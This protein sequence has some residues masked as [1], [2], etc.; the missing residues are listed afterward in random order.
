MTGCVESNIVDG[1][2]LSGRYI[3]WYGGTKCLITYKSL[4]DISS[5]VVYTTGNWGWSFDKATIYYSDDDSLTLDSDLSNFNSI[6][7]N[8]ESWQEL[9]EII[10]AK[11]VMLVKHENGAV[12]EFECLGKWDYEY[13]NGLVDYWP[14][15]N[16]LENA[17][18][19]GSG[20]LQIEKGSEPTYT[21]DGVYL[22]N[23][24]LSTQNYYVMPSKYSIVF[25]IKPTQINRWSWVAGK[26]LYIAGHS[27]YSSGLW[28]RDT[29]TEPIVSCGDKYDS[30]Y[31][32]PGVGIYN[33]NEQSTIVITHDGGTMSLYVDGNLIGT[34]KA[35]NYSNVSHGKFY[36]GGSQL[37]G[38]NA[39]SGIVEGYSPGYYKNVRIYNKALTAQ[40]IQNLGF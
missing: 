13:E 26:K 30:S 4:C 10:Q 36:L 21:S 8:T 22:N 1:S 12:Y 6:T 39:G 14:L 27:P 16:S 24:V 38:E 35:K 3:N 19:Y 18:N 32:R 31:I 20:N 11:R 29:N 2:Y 5:M 15:N 7:I 25:Q 40:E 33:V 23:I 9:N 37:S 17:I 34:S 28:M